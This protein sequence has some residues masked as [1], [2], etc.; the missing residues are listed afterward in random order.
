VAKAPARNTRIWIDEHALSGYLSAAEIKVEQE[1]VKVD[2]FLSSGPERVVG[3]HDHS[4]SFSGFFDG[5]DDA[6]DEIA[7]SDLRTDED[8]YAFV[9]FGAATEGTYGYERVVRLKSQPRS[10]QVGQAVLLNLEDEGSGPIVR[11]TILRSAAVTGTGNGTG[12]NLGATT[13]GQLFV[14]TYRILSV[15]GAGSIVLNTQESQ[16]DGSP[17]TYANITA[18]ASGTLTGV[19]V[20]RKTTTS[21]TEAWKRIAVSTFSGFTSVTVLVTAGTAPTQ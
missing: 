6:F 15:S 2:N 10:A 19:G 13:S 7:F 18:L 17:D 21:A 5:A 8:H 16:N 9:A 11:A 4:A 20:T 14:V 3:N 12:R 1:T